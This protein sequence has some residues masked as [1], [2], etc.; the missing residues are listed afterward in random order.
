MNITILDFL[1]S[2][3]GAPIIVLSALLAF[4]RKI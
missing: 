4:A 1:V 3:V 2:V